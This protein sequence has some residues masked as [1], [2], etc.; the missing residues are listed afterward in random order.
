VSATEG[1]FVTR[2][3]GALELLAD[4]PRST[5]E[6]AESLAIHPRTARRMLARLVDEGYVNPPPAPRTGYSLAPRFSTLAARALLQQGVR[7]PGAQQ[8][9]AARAQQAAEC[10]V[11]VVP[12]DNSG[13]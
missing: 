7:R 2:T 6:I 8:D 9:G 4:A 11:V 1:Y 5:R 3:V 12:V 13:R 10:L